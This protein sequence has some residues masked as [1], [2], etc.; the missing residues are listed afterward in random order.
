MKLNSIAVATDRGNCDDLLI[1]IVFHP[2]GQGFGEKW[3]EFSGWL[4]AL[5]EDAEVP[6]MVFDIDFEGSV[7]HSSSHHA[8]HIRTSSPT[9]RA[10]VFALILN[11]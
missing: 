5:H 4:A 8:F 7:C 11:R 6:H 1:R 9:S 3:C 2:L 10:R